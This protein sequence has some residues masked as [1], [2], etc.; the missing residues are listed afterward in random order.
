MIIYKVRSRSRSAL[1]GAAL[2]TLPY[3]ATPC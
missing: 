1:L 2:H 3:P